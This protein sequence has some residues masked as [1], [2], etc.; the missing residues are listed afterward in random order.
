MKK[1][2][3][4]FIVILFGVFGCSSEEPFEKLQISQNN[5]TIT[6]GEVIYLETNAKELNIDEIEWTSG[7]D[8]VAIVDQGIVTGVGVGSVFITATA[9]EFSTEVRI[10]V[11]E[12]VKKALKITGK[13]SILVG[14]S[15][16]LQV[17][18]LSS[19]TIEWESSD[20]TV[21]TVSD[22]VVTGLKDGIVTIT[23]K[24]TH[25]ASVYGEYLIYVYREPSYYEQII[26]T[27]K[28]TTFEFNGEMDLTALS[29][30]ITNTIANIGNAFV[31]VDNYVKIGEGEDE[32]FN[33]Q[34]IGS[35]IIFDRVDNESNY[36]Y[37]L[38]S[39]Y[40]V[41]EDADRVNVYLGYLDEEIE[42]RVIRHDYIL[43]L[44]ILEFDSEVAINPIVIADREVLTGEFV[45]AI[46][47]PTGFDYFGSVT[48]GIVSHPQRYV[49]KG[50]NPRNQRYIQHDAAINSGNSGGPLINID[51]ELIGIN[52]LKLVDISVEGMGFA[53]PSD[54][55]KQFISQG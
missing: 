18:N 14:N 26:N 30:K 1:I 22:G 25:D 29:N 47:N 35:G 33:R 8:L 28:R 15:I 48:F 17:E 21:A 11:E 5:F 27:I 6:V 44:A 2:L 54:V 55:I 4:I 34:A 32:S 38:L 49:D 40:H 19:Q 36:T 50:L 12:S 31:G 43:D 46:G 23:A 20:E 37:L 41:I 51:G 45:L 42:A 10:I 16:S 9:G 24:L 39:N 13:Q 7:N 3:I 53:I 52:T